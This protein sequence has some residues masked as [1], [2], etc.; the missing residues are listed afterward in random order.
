MS[1]MIGMFLTFDREIALLGEMSCE[2]IRA[3]N[4]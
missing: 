1:Y 2:T 3:F 4:I